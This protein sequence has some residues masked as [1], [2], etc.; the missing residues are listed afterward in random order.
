MLY[1]CHKNY[2]VISLVWKVHVCIHVFSINL[3]YDGVLGCAPAAHLGRSAQAVL[4]S[5][6]LY[7]DRVIGLND[8]HGIVL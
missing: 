7:L 5:S 6:C 1:S 3:S 8:M 2:V 4:N